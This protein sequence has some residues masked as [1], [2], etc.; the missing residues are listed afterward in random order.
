MLAYHLRRWTNIIP[1]ISLSQGYC[2]MF[3]ATLNVS[4]RH[5]RQA[6]INP[7]LVLSIVPV[8]MLHKPTID[9]SMCQCNMH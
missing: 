2:V 1:V 8:Y 3:D 5:R 9:P 4:Q 6:N 7:A